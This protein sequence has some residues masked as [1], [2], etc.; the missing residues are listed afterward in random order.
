MIKRLVL[1][2]AA[3]VVAIMG[4]ATN[5]RPG[6][7]SADTSTLGWDVQFCDAGFG[8]DIAT[9]CTSVLPGGVANGVNP[10]YVAH[11]ALQLAGGAPSEPFF[12]LAT[13][14][15]TPNL[16]TAPAVGLGT[17]A[18]GAI[19]G[20]IKFSLS[21]NTDLALTGNVVPT[22]GA[23]PACGGAGTLVV[24]PP[25]ADQYASAATPVANPIMTGAGF[26]FAS[27][28]QSFDDDDNDLVEYTSG[29]D[30]DDGGDVYPQTQA[31][32]N[33]NG[34]LDGADRMPDFIPRLLNAAGI[35]SVFKSRSYGVAIVA[36][37]QHVDVNFLNLDLTG[38]GAGYVSI[39]T[40][41]VVDPAS[42][43]NPA[44][45]AQT[46]LTCPPFVSS[47]ST[48]GVTRDNPATLADESGV[49]IRVLDNTKLGGATIDFAIGV[50]TVEDYDGSVASGLDYCNGDASSN[51]DGDAD[52][53][54]D[55]CEPAGKTGTPDNCGAGECA[56]LLTNCITSGGVGVAGSGVAGFE[57]GAAATGYPW[58]LDQDIDCDGAA[59]FADNCPSVPNGGSAALP[60]PL[61][62]VQ[63][64]ADGDTQGD[65][66]DPKPALGNARSGVP[67]PANS[68]PDGW[69]T[70]NSDHDRNCNDPV[71]I[72]GPG[73]GF[74]AGY[75]DSTCV[76]GSDASDDGIMDFN[77]A[78]P[79]G[80]GGLGQQDVNSDSD[81]DG[82][83]DGEEADG[84]GNCDGNVINADTDGDSTLDGAELGPAPDFFLCWVY[85]V[86][87]NATTSLNPNG[88]GSP[89]SD[90][91]GCSN[92]EENLVGRNALNPYD[93]S[94]VPGPATNVGTDGKLYFRSDAARSK[95]ITLGDASVVLAYVG[96][97]STNAGAAYYNGDWNNDS[98]PDGF[99]M[100]RTAGGGAPNNAVTLADVSIIL[101][102][103]AGSSCVSPP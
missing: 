57:G 85:D 75:A 73:E 71:T 32:T 70:T 61:T 26:N 69:T 98:I 60:H 12:D 42:I 7:V 102:Q 30:A 41:G 4:A 14:A 93:Y 13:T 67:K 49:A 79:D 72:D 90:N 40:I 16:V 43:Y 64:D 55:P 53:L 59:N 88:N 19:V 54:A 10:T 25:T 44:T 48:L 46:T 56:T 62:G 96:R 76:T 17:P 63:R 22:T 21:S 50:S 77:A 95:S 68:I 8:A 28:V 9:T 2:S 6:P 66:C 99:Q 33:G 45:A 15:W 34:I 20:Q 84:D 80:A 35:G 87:E 92:Y 83:S 91:D 101:G 94:D 100:D 47:T 52:R 86:L 38:L 18:T 82:V 36:V 97:T 39:T 89:D 24:A 11:L 81:F 1:L 37:P 23:P 3:L 103:I 78:A 29:I 58:T 5:H 65:A 31:D 74:G 51:A 27:Y